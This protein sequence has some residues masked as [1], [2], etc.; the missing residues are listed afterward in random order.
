MARAWN[1][2]VRLYGPDDTLIGELFDFPDL[3]YP[4]L[5]IAYETDT[6]AVEAVMAVPAHPRSPAAQRG[7]SP[8]LV[9]CRV[10]PVEGIHDGV[11][12]R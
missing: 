7:E 4:G 3:P 9:D 5:V 1:F 2:Q 11:T 10:R 6:W 8:V 12:F